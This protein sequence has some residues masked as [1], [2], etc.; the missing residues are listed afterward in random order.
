M[1]VIKTLN[2]PL[3]FFYKLY[4]VIYSLD[5][6]FFIVIFFLS[7]M[8]SLDIDSTLLSDIVQINQDLGDY[9]E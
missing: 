3:Y 6:H 7:D 8:T 9:F 4:I 2:K 5:F 1:F